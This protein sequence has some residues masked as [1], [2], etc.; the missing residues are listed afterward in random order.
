ML[1]CLLPAYAAP[2]DPPGIDKLLDLSLDDLLNISIQVG[3]RTGNQR[4]GDFSQRIDVLTAA[5]LRRTGL[6]ELPKVLN[7]LLP[8]FTYAF[9][10]LDDLT[11][12][13]RPFS[14]GGL[15]GD[16]VL[17]L[18]NG[19]RVHRTAVLDVGDSQMR[20]S[21]SVDLN[22]IPIEAI[23][24]IEVLHDDASAQ[25]GSDAIAGVINIVLK[26]D[27]VNEVVALGGQ[28][29][30]GDGTLGTVSYNHGAN[31]HFF[32]LELQSKEYSNTSGPDRRDYYFPGD[33]RNGEYQITQRYGDPEHK[34]LTLTFSG[35]ANQEAGFY[36]LGKLTV[37]HSEGAGFFRRPEDDRDVRSI[38]PNGFLPLE[39]LDQND[40]FLS[41]G[42]K[43]T[44]GGFALDAS[45]TFGYNRANISVN[46]SLN[47]SLGAASPTSFDAGA[48]AYWQ[49]SFNLDATRPIELGY[50]EAAQLAVG[51]EFRYENYLQFAGE[52]SSWEYGGAPVLDGP[53]AGN[54]TASGAQAFPG[55]LPANAV[56]ISRSVAAVY[57]E[58][59]QKFT[60]TLNAKIALRDE[61]YSDFGNTFNGKLLLNF[62]PTDS[63]ALR[64][65]LG[66]GFKAPTLQ[67]MGYY[68]TTTALDSTT[69]NIQTFGYFP[70]DNPLSVALGAK[71]LKPE[72]S[73]RL[74]LGMTWHPA[75]HLNA[76]IDY[77][78]IKIR[79]RIA[80]TSSISNSGSL[81]PQAQAL[82]NSLNVNSAQYF[83]NA[84]DTTTQ[85]LALSLSDDFTLPH[86]QLGVKAQYEH[87]QTVINALHIPAELMSQADTVFGR[88]E[89]ERLTN[90]LPHDKAVLSLD[91][92]TGPFDIVTRAT[93]Y[94]K[95]LYVTDSSNPS[96]DQWFAAK[97][98]VD[99]DL[100]Y[101]YDKSLTLS[102][103]AHNLFNTY[104]DYRNSNP[105]F[106]GQG[107]IL[108]YRGISPFDYTGGWYYVR[109]VYVF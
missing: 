27:D 1:G 82:M 51:S 60:N 18:I 71:P 6:G 91:Y 88:D 75:G 96:L 33:P 67:E 50:A 7:V 16:Q 47:A 73:T 3:S 14:L 52:R 87:N 72:E 65:S 43:A 41:G 36:Y 37:R 10:T 107:N 23:S 19:K 77:S 53:D 93:Y 8:S 70:V 66:T 22:L 24:R 13:V 109:G 35:N 54:I 108:Q 95:V 92:R 44:L 42:Y 46:H 94:G 83:M 79:D 12:H 49:D 69:G 76:G 78:V 9:S 20:G 5:D 11:D 17:V 85:S 58:L 56:N 101:R 62:R 98:L 68:H 25:Y 74:N 39:V 97:T 99:M 63:V 80:L 90:Y 4:L 81:P 38:Y 61:S 104:P 40:A 59:D 32:S 89:Q 28:R 31:G 29:Y 64:G 21:A 48:L 34:S 84:A 30:A 106:N 100:S 26:S 57:G 15:K 105:P 103:G 2:A 55:F 45:N 86:G 102:I